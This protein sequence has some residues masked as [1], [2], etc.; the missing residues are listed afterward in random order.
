MRMSVRGVRPAIRAGRYT[1]VDGVDM[2]GD[3]LQALKVSGIVA[4]GLECEKNPRCAFFVYGTFAWGNCAL[5]CVKAAVRDAGGMSLRQVQ[6]CAQ[7]CAG[8]D[9]NRGAPWMGHLGDCLPA[10]HLPLSPPQPHPAAF[11]SVP[12]CAPAASQVPRTYVWKAA[13][14][15]TP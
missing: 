9:G 15:G 7:V 12:C 3:N 1:C 5:R 6:V 4:C 8:A 13:G 10:R 14:L 2:S 11:L